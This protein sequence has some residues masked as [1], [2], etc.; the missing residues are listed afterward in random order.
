MCQSRASSTGSKCVRSVTAHSSEASSC[1]LMGWNRVSSKAEV[2]AY[3][4]SP[5]DSG[6]GSNVPMQ[7]RSRFSC[8]ELD[9]VFHVTKRGGAWSASSSRSSSSSSVVASCSA[10]ALSTRSVL[11]LLWLVT[12]L[13][14]SLALG[15]ELALGR[16]EELDD[17][18][19]DARMREMGAGFN[20]ESA[21]GAEPASS[22]T[23]DAVRWYFV[24][25]DSTL[26]SESAGR[27]S[28]LATRL[29]KQYAQCAWVA[30]TSVGWL[31]RHGVRAGVGIRWE[32]VGIV[33][34]EPRGAQ[35][36]VKSTW[37]YL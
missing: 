37:V 8:E 18:D 22:S 20:D 28:R 30:M 6:S 23:P 34:R 2:S 5:V 3:D 13:C 21:A 31:V 33:Q 4:D 36:R 10:A 15:V 26:A 11:L 27:F 19:G 7:P 14:V 35:V 17:D 16:L 1:A 29:S 12:L 9:I 32:R 25:R 24:H